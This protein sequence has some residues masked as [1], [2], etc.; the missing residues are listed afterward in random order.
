MYP[1]FGLTRVGNYLYFVEQHGPSDFDLWRTD[2]TAVGTVRLRSFAPEN[3]NNLSPIG[4]IIDVGG[5]AYFAAWDAS[6][7]TELWTSDGTSAG[8]VLVED[9]NPGPNSSYPQS[10]TNADGSV[11]FVASDGSVSEPLW[12]LVIPTVPPGSPGALTASASSAFT[13][14]LTWQSPAGEVAGLTLQRSLTP[15]FSSIRDSI[16]L[17]PSMTSYS[18]PVAE[19]GS[20]NYYRL[21]AFNAAGQSNPVTADATTPAFSYTPGSIIQVDAAATWANPTNLTFFRGQVY[22]VA[23]AP[24]GGAAFRTD[25]IHSAQ[26]LGNS[27]VGLS[28]SSDGNSLD[29]SQQV[30]GGTVQWQSDGSA[31]G[32]FRT[33]L[34]FIPN[35]ARRAGNASP[36]DLASQG[37]TPISYTTLYGQ[38]WFFAVPPG[39]NDYGLY[40]T[41]GT[42]QGTVLLYRFRPWQNFIPGDITGINGK[43]VFD[44]GTALDVS[45]GTPAGSTQLKSFG[46]YNDPTLS[47]LTAVGAQ[48]YFAVHL[49]FGQTA[50]G[51]TE[52]NGQLWVSDGT[53]AGTKQVPGLPITSPVSQSPAQLV[54]FGGTL[55]F[56]ADDPI[57]QGRLFHYT[58]SPVVLSAP[59]AP[60]DLKAAALYGEEIDLTWADHSNN[61]EGFRLERSASPTFATVDESLVVPMDSTSYNDT[62]LAPGTTYYYS[63]VA[64]N[65]AGD[66]AAVLS[67][68]LATPLAPPA[69][70]NL[71][72]VID[73]PG[74]AVDLS[75]Q[76]H[77]AP[78][79]GELNVV[80]QRS[81]RSDFATLDFT[82]TLPAGTTSYI[83]TTPNALSQYFYRVESVN[84]AGGSGF[85]AIVVQTPLFPPNTPSNLQAFGVSGSEIDLQ[86]TDGGNGTQ[87]YHIQ[88]AGADGTFV[89]IAQTPV[90]T[91]TFSDTTA[92]S[93][94]T[95]NYRIIASN[96]AG[97]S[98]VS[99][100]ATATTLPPQL[101]TPVTSLPALVDVNTAQGGLFN[102]VV[103]VGN[104]GYFLTENM[105]NYGQELWKTDGTAAGTSLVKNLGRVTSEQAQN[106]L[107]SG[108]LFYFTCADSIG[109]V[110]LWR[111]D[112]TPDGTIPLIGLFTITPGDW[113]QNNPKISNAVDDNGTLFLGGVSPHGGGTLFESDGTVAGSVAVRSFTSGPA[114]LEVANGSLYFQAQFAWWTSDGTPAGTV[115]MPPQFQPPPSP[116][117]SLTPA[118]SNSLPAGVAAYNLTQAGQKVVFWSNQWNAAG[119]IFYNEVWVSDG[120]AAG[121]IQLVKLPYG[122]NVGISDFTPVGNLVYFTL[123]GP[124][125]GS[126]LW[127]SDLT[128]GGTVKVT[129]LNATFSNLAACTD[130]IVNTVR[131]A[132]C[133][134]CCGTVSGLT[135]VGKGGRAGGSGWN[136]GEQRAAST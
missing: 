12:K 89:E 102:P 43:V 42:P 11:V 95:Y 109:N 92:A 82:Q 37:L 107:A 45:D 33:T 40:R 118:A 88:R 97:A 10:L 100:S 116:M 93:D 26:I 110:T 55:W 58:P 36:D 115:Q 48:V 38:G 74:R 4:N 49:P 117:P 35:I 54:N 2:G 16:T 57:N 21:M 91:S 103:R 83:D 31:Q 113:P 114:A 105:A 62:G 30:A 15:D 63:L 51:E 80:L 98:D 68:A 94:S 71:A 130:Q 125:N 27:V 60:D 73:V 56:T 90:G 14:D 70:S 135:G 22:F 66:S 75:W 18:D 46:Q 61:E 121:T 96:A 124:A 52:Y 126:E 104:E 64:L 120:T 19:A 111:T 47:N 24:D 67:G 78:A 132:G 1:D 53:T 128:P 133:F 25:G 106:V 32:T 131:L 79:D 29:I 6:H 41:D 17:A 87:T 3:S 81:S 136:W 5:Q 34:P 119:T 76:D 85:I 84:A 20:M 8:T 99:V 101:A 123:F 44:D 77:A 69:A 50:N 39:E 7:G 13:V 127:K 9:L 86:W 134:Y 59:A 112:G 28:L 129:T 72:A 23:T 122:G 108:G 65:D